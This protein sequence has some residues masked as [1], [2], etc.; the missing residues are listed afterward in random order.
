MGAPPRHTDLAAEPEPFAEAVAR[1]A[2]IARRRL[3]IIDLELRTSTRIV[4]ARRAVPARW[5]RPITHGNW[6]GTGVVPDVATSSDA[7]LDE[8]LKRAHSDFK[9]P[10]A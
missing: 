7:A 4:D 1:D 9:H 8:A 5:M 2:R 3:D 6:E 10:Y